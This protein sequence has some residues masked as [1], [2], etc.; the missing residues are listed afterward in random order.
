VWDEGT[1]NRILEA[2][3]EPQGVEAIARRSTWRDRRLAA[4]KAH[5][6]SQSDA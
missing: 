4:L 2:W 1:V 5:K 3:G 6:R